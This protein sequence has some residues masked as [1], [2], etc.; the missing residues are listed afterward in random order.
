LVRDVVGTCTLWNWRYV[1]VVNWHTLVRTNLFKFFD[2]WVFII[3]TL[4]FIS[5]QWILSFFLV[6]LGMEHWNFHII[7]SSLFWKIVLVIAPFS[8]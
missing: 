4:Y 1:K 3:L 8:F 5:K 7:H 2:E 6:D